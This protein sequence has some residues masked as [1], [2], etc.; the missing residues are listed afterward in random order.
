MGLFDDVE[1]LAGNAVGQNEEDSL[2]QDA[3]QEGEQFLENKTGGHFDSEIQQGG[4][5]LDQQVDQDLP[6]L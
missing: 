4:D 6:N 3:T 2:V 5:Q 1:K